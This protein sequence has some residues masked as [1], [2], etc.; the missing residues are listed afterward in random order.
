MRM[1]DGR[2]FEV[3]MNHSPPMKPLAGI[4]FFDAWRLYP[5][6]AE[7][8]PAARPSSEPLPNLQADGEGPETKSYRKQA[9]EREWQQQR[10]L[11]S[12][13]AED[14][15]IHASAQYHLASLDEAWRARLNGNQSLRLA[16][17]ERIDTIALALHT[18]HRTL[19][20]LG[21]V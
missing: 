15:E 10:A 20:G 11:L 14:Y 21:H 1:E 3:G 2:L 5:Q 6:M 8:A 7:M 18:I 16:E 19:I 17:L 9:L 4:Y 12:Q 13:D